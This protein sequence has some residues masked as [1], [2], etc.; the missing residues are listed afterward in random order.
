[1]PALLWDR[2]KQ[3]KLQKWQAILVIKQNYG[4]TNQQFN[5]RRLHHHYHHQHHHHHH[6][7]ISNSFRHQFTQDSVA[8]CHTPTHKFKDA[9]VGKKDS[10]TEGNIFKPKVTGATNIIYTAMRYPGSQPPQHFGC[11]NVRHTTRSWICCGPLHP[12]HYTV[13][14]RTH[15]WN[16]TSLCIR[17]DEP[18][19]CHGKPRA[20][21]PHSSL[22]CM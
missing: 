21:A 5:Q 22:G 6:H 12:N 15:Q 4:I 8:G 10:V 13:L 1:M 7:L 3:H 11:N 16:I 14:S 20:E 18:L 17:L 2:G 19:R 9:I